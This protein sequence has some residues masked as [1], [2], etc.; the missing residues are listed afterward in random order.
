MALSKTQ[1][2]VMQ[3]QNNALSPTA[4][5]FTIQPVVTDGNLVPGHARRN[6]GVFTSGTAPEA[7]SSNPNNDSNS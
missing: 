5:S 6:P 3:N 2:L 7:T 4:V 1:T